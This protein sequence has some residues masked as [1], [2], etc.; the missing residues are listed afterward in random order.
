MGTIY[1]LLARLIL[2]VILA[3][4][5]SSVYFNGIQIYKTGALAAAMFALSYMFEL[6]RKR[7]RGENDK[8]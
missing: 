4:V 8:D 6:T 1:I 5:I 3:S 7:D 2:A